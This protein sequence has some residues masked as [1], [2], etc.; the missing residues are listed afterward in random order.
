MLV[1]GDRGSCVL[2]CHG[3]TLAIAESTT[4]I[5]RVFTKRAL[6]TP[7]TMLSDGLPLGQTSPRKPG[8]QPPVEVAALAESAGVSIASLVSELG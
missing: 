7:S 8:A 5:W 2:L 1:R 4:R 3:Y 6:S